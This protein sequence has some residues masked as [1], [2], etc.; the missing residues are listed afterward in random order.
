MI[1]LVVPYMELKIY[2]EHFDFVVYFCISPCLY[3]SSIRFD[4]SE[5]VTV[6]PLSFSPR[7]TSSLV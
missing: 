7:R 1:Y 2:Q 4:A 5:R 3:N 6:W